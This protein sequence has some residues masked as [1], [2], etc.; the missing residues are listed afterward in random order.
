MKQLILSFLMI[1][2]ITGCTFT[3]KASDGT[4]WSQDLN[5]NLICAK[6]IDILPISINGAK[7]PQEAFDFSMSKIK[8][9]TTDNIVVHKTVNLKIAENDVNDFIQKF[10][11]YRAGFNK[12]TPT[13]GAK[14]RKALKDFPKDKT[15][16]VMIYTPSLR[17]SSTGK[18]SLRGLAYHHAPDYN[19]V[20]YN[21]TTIDKAPVISKT[22][23]WKIVLT[24]EIGHRFKLPA[25]KDRVN[26]GHCTRRECVLYA[27]PD[28][29]AVLSVLR[30]GMPYD[31]CKECRT[32]LKKA[33]ESCEE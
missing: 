19:V 28:W 8:Q 31:F 16:I 27:K 22:Q 14:L 18:N 26:N 23:A 15:G 25:N 30:Y 32:E 7:P 3:P 20:A 2:T 13:E 10:G 5:K 12:I 11:T 1:F 21:Q 29:R 9:Y 33:K 24:H 6:K 4:S 17:C